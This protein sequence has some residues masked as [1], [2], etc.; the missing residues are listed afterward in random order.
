M[1]VHQAGFPNVVALMGCSLSTKQADLLT[2]H[3]SEVILLLDGDEAGEQ[4]SAKIA[5]NLSGRMRVH[6]GRVPMGFQPDQ[7]SVD[8]LRRIIENAMC[9]P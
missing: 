6:R 1:N 5:L 7:L 3:F 9:D 2:R 4:A 8:E